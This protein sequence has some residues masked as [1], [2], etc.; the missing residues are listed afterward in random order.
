MTDIKVLHK[1][2]NKIFILTNS[3]E[4]EMI[5][6][7]RVLSNGESVSLMKQPIQIK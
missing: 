3:D 5:A 2:L 7:R 6:Q 4:H 1:N